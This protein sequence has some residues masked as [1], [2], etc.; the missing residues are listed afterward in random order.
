MKKLL[1]LFSL[2]FSALGMHAQASPNDLLIVGYVNSSSIT[3]S[4]VPNWP[5][6][7]SPDNGVTFNQVLTDASGFYSFNIT[8][9]SQIGPNLDFIVFTQSCDLSTTF[10]D[11]VSNNQGTVDSAFVNFNINCGGNQICEAPIYSFVSASAQFYFSTVD[12]PGLIASYNWTIDAFDQNG[13]TIGSTQTST[14]P[15]VGYYTNPSNVPAY[16]SVC[17]T[18]TYADGCVASFCDNFYYCNAEFDAAV[19]SDNQISITALSPD[20]TTTNFNWSVNGIAY[21]GAT[22]TLNFQGDPNE[23]Y[24]VCLNIS[25]PLGCS[26]TWCDTITVNNQIDTCQAGFS[27]VLSP[28]VPGIGYPV[29][30]FTTYTG[31]EI[32][33]EHL[34]DF[35]NGFTSSAANLSTTLLQ[36]TGPITVC[37][38]VIN[39]NTNC[40]NNYCQTITLPDTINNNCS[41]QI[42]QSIEADGS[43]SY[44]ANSVD[45]ISQYSWIANAYDAFGNSLFIVSNAFAP[46]ITIPANNAYYFV[47]VCATLSFTNG[48]QIQNC[49]TYYYP[50]DTTL[51]TCDASFN[52]SVDG[53]ILSLVPTT[54]NPGFVN[55]QW[56]IGNLVVDQIDPVV[57][58]PAGTY[59]VCLYVWDG[60]GCQDYSCQTITINGD[61]TY[62]YCEAYFNYTFSSADL[63]VNFE[64]WSFSAG[65]PNTVT[66]SWDFGDN[67][68]SNEANPIH[69]YPAAGWYVASLTINQGGCS[70]T[71]SNYIWVGNS[72]TDCSASFNNYSLSFTAPYVY[73]FVSNQTGFSQEYNH[74]WTFS[75]GQIS[76]DAN[77]IVVFPTPGN[78]TVCHYVQNSVPGIVCNDSLCMSFEIYGVD[79]LGCSAFFTYSNEAAQ[80]GYITFAPY[81]SDASYNYEWQIGGQTFTEMNPSYLFTTEGYHDVCL[82]VYGAN[83]CFDSY[84]TSIYNAGTGISLLNIWGNVFAGANIADVGIAYLVAADTTSGSMQTL[85]ETP[86]VGG[87]YY[88]ANI[89]EGTYFIRAE[90]SNGSVYYNNYVPTYF[91][92]QYYWELAEP[93][94]LTAASISPYGYTIALIYAGN[95]GGPGGIGGMVDE[96]PIRLM[97]PEASGLAEGPVSG[98][99]VLVTDLYGNPQ[100]WTKSNTNGGFSIGNLDYGTYRLMADVAGIPCVPIEFTIAPG[101]ENFDIMLV[102]GDGVT[103]VANPIASEFITEVFPN[104][105]KDLGSIRLNKLSAGEI[106]LDIINLAGQTIVSKKENVSAGLQNLELPVSGL[107]NGSYLVNITDAAGNRI[108]VKRLSIAH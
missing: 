40:T 20:I 19:F 4:G 68:V 82:T 81:I 71:Y 60:F 50:G 57:Y 12:A 56:Y 9:G 32:G 107:A 8:N 86:I 16:L 7:Y 44:Q 87:S 104:P 74:Y 31:S 55:A 58:L 34:W 49:E 96:G 106:Q 100:R 90:L 5:V 108:G 3:P 27:Y 13:Q 62:G 88:F 26:A 41:F 93:I 6:F 94:N 59:D 76:F 15:S 63:T 75:D 91:G 47:E 83:G 37:H 18:L 89:P 85:M 29:Q 73:Q 79:S 95:N 97:S 99:N 80:P 52:Y 101:F 1:F 46:T 30:F 22:G 17:L 14:Q 84:C 103:S 39:Y 65:D 43:I 45:T 92:S 54:I 105:A 10:L 67:T 77:P 42:S 48:C 51:N 78:Y 38:T 11:T 25:S 33:V 36:G 24:L 69:T 23:N 35:S 66:Y 98:A 28:L 72:N 61:S 53:N 102:L 2:L 21:P 64:N 70:H